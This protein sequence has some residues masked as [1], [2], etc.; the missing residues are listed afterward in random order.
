MSE[1]FDT[2]PDFSKLHAVALSFNPLL[3]SVMNG[4]LG[5]VAD[6][7]FRKFRDIVRRE[8]C[9]AA[10]GHRVPLR[11]VEPEDLPTPGAALLYFHGGA[12]IMKHTPQHVINA[13]SYARGSRCRVIF[14]DYRLA[15]RH[16]FP[17]PFHDCYAALQWAL[18]NADRLGID[19]RRIAVGGDSAGG[20]LAASAAQK[21][22]DDGIELCGQLLLYPV[23]DADCNTPSGQRFVDV[24]PM[25]RYSTRA[26]WEAYL[27]H[28]IEA[29]KARYASP[30]HGKLEGLAPAYVETTEFDPLHDESLAYASALMASGV[31]VELN[32]THRTVHGYDLVAPASALSKAA[33]AARVQFLRKIFQS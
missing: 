8:S 9:V 31:D 17:A 24:A 19:R 10:D 23:A 33:I 4:A 20:A 13:V 32:E 28:A 3:L 27:G 22:R 6:V 2:H 12:F 11:V 16:P 7:K 14:V 15:P 30:L 18:Q 1:Q 26:S 29:D 21:A 5:L 25:K